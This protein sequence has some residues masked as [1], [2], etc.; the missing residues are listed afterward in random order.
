MTSAGNVER[1]RVDVG[2]AEL[3]V[4]SGGSSGTDVPVICA[5]H[6]GESFDEGTVGLLAAAA[7]A[8]VVC[9]NMRGIGGSSALPTSASPS[10]ENMVEDLDAVRQRL[11]IRPWL[12]WGMSGGGWLAE[13]Y[14]RRHP[15]GLSGVIVESCCQC[16]RERLAD[17]QCALSPFHPMWRAKL[18][19]ARLLDPNA[20]ADGGT[21][22]LEWVELD[23]IGSVFRRRGGAALLVTAKPLSSEMRRVMPALWAMDARKWWKHVRLPTLVL[24]GTADPIVPL[25]HAKAVHDAVTNSTFVAIE[26]AGHVPTAAKRPEAIGAVRAFLERLAKRR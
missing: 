18:E 2:S 23:G 22:G 19:A 24:A 9:I 20:H 11:G 12:F 6:P 1:Q 14:A 10:L 16:F 26:G 8:R 3:E 15:E 25:A 5:A 17:A 21:S 4:I 13:I 7:N